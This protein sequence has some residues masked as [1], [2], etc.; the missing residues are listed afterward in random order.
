MLLILAA[1]TTTSESENQ[2]RLR[3]RSPTRQRCPVRNSKR[4]SVFSSTSR[5]HPS[6]HNQIKQTLHHITLHDPTTPNPQLKPSALPARVPTD[7]NP[8]RVEFANSLVAQIRFAVSAARTV[9]LGSAAWQAVEV[10]E[11]RWAA[12]LG[13]GEVGAC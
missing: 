10:R 6:T 7:V 12:W 9:P 2:F 1:P 13:G 4:Q 8:R 11:A 3:F 5:P